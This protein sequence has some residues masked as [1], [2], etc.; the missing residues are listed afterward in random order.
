MNQ[1]NQF[2]FNTASRI[3]YGAGCSANTGDLISQLPII[4]KTKLV[5]MIITDSTLSRLGLHLDVCASLNTLGFETLVFD[6]VT[7]DPIESTVL[8]ASNIARLKSVDAIIGFG[9]GSAMDV[10][11]LVAYLACN[12]VSLEQIYG[13]NKATGMRLPLVL[14]PTTAGTG[15]EVTPVTIVSNDA[16]EKKGA[17]SP[18][19]IPDLIL[20]DPQLTYGLPAHITAATSIDAVIHALESYTSINFNQNPISQNLARDA[21]RLL[22]QNIKTAVFKGSDP[23]ARAGMLLGSFLAGQAF[24][25]AP[26]AAVHALSYPLSGQFHISHGEANAAILTQVMRFNQVTCS[27]QYAVLAMD[28]FPHIPLSLTDEEKSQSLI[29]QLDVL[30]SELGLKTRLSDFG[31]TKN[32]LF[33]L[34]EDA[35]TQ[36]RLLTNNPRPV[37]LEDAVEIFRRAL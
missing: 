18:L 24:A 4:S 6:E 36:V 28:M 21:L 23:D 37:T 13:V 26:V 34:A 30:L 17:V 29:E 25:N 2:T 5:V 3:N 14:I 16:S 8:K 31:I 10:A 32:D 11:K 1:F 27:R 12:E 15:A 7:P 19:F 20:L 33:S 35:M 22:M 9:G